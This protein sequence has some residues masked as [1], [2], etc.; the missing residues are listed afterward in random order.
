MI[1]T[2]LFL[3]GGLVAAEY[4]GGETSELFRT[5]YGRVNFP[6]YVNRERNCF[7]MGYN[8]ERG[9][10]GGWD[11]YAEQII[12][13][14]LGAASPTCPT[15]PSLY[16]SFTRDRGTYEDLE[17]IHT[18]TGS[19]FTYQFSHAWIDFR[20]IRDRDG[21]DWFE[22]SV[23]ASLANWKYCSGEEKTTEP[24]TKDRGDS[25]PATLRTVT[26][27]ISEHRLRPN[28]TPRTEPTE[29]CRPVARSVRSSSSLG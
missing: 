3:M 17:L 16:Y 10:W 22:N 26:G 25:P 2:A 28:P 5:I 12:M 4:F 8:Y 11:R 20:K 13:Y 9:F 29:P 18:Y 19:L 14:V 1:D 7:Y 23:R 21:V 24:C 6:W 27:G 15:D